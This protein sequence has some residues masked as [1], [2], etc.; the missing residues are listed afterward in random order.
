MSELEDFRKAKDEFFA[1][2]PRSPLSP[3]Q[4]AGFAGLAYYPENP[5]LRIDAAL[6][7]GVD[8]VE[9]I[10]LGTTTGGVQV[11]RRAG[12]LRFE[13]EGVPAQVTLFA[14]PEM[15]DLFLPF[16]DAT[17]GKETYGAG[18]YLEVDPP[19]PDGRV[20]ADLNHAYNP[21]CC[22]DE[23]WSC[24]LP[25][26]ENWLDIPIRAGEKDFPWES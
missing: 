10:P 20:V 13:V 22:Y 1:N 11:Y 18:R 8:R 24:P 26:R 12:V 5:E 6:D 16:R 25:P 19:G 17:S 2:D 9:G 23:N 3:Q 21:Y 14:S 7:T 15:D 4:R